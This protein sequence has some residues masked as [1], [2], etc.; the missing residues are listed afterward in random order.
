MVEL[1]QWVAHGMGGA[2][3]EED[4]HPQEQSVLTR[5][6]DLHQTCILN[7]VISD[8]KRTPHGMEPRLLGKE[9]EEEEGGPQHNG[10]QVTP[11]GRL[12]WETGSKLPMRSTRR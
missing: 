6:A 4:Y 1:N 7:A 5:M 9:E 3:R 12:R 8:G 2:R 11:V 10:W